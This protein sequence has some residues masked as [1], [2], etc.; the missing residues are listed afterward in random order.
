MLLPLKARL[1]LEKTQ[2]RRRTGLPVVS[3]LE[4]HRNPAVGQ[5]H[6]RGMQPVPGSAA[7]V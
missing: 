2:R 3:L 5:R 7:L 4:G 1:G 6:R